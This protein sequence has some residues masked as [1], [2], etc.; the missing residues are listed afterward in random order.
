MKDHSY[1]PS[2]RSSRFGGPTTFPGWQKVGSLFCSQRD[3]LEKQ[4]PVGAIDRLVTGV[5]TLPGS[6]TVHPH[7]GLDSDGPG[8]D[9]TR[10][11]QSLRLFRIAA[12]RAQVWSQLARKKARCLVSPR[13]VL[14]NRLMNARE[15]RL[16]DLTRKASQ[17]VNLSDVPLYVCF[18][19]VCH[20]GASVL[21]SAVRPLGH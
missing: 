2:M 18:Q 21:R 10:I 12:S 5:I 9:S 11:A 17:P 19:P 8:A 1:L 7:R 14:P 16:P 3:N 4:S 6:A 20:T 13:A 15:K